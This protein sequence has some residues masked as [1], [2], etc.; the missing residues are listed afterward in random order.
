MEPTTTCIFCLIGKP[1]SGKNAIIKN[2][3]DRK[4]CKE[5]NLE[6]LVYGTTRPMTPSDIEGV[7]YHFLSNKDFENISPDQIIES[8]SYDSIYTGNICYYFTLKNYIRFGTNYI[9]KISTFQYQDLKQWAFKS[10]LQNTANRIT[11]YPIYVQAPLFVREK[12]MIS[13]AATDED[14]YE[15]CSRIVTEQFEFKSVVE[16]NPE[17]IDSMSRNTCILDNGK[18]GSNNINAVGDKLEKFIKSRISMQG[19]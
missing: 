5:Y 12:R 6:K 17:I 2:I 14:I 18:S 15:I 4:F 3:L 7:S 16:N 19:L 1:G 10:Q 8:R 11:I 9:G 13:Q